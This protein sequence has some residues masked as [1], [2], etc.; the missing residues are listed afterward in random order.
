M[1]NAK[2]SLKLTIAALA[3]AWFMSGC[4][5]QLGQMI[6]S[7]TRAVVDVP[8][9]Q[10]RSAPVKGFVKLTQV[11]DARHFEAAPRNPSV[12]SLQNA[13]QIKDSS[14]TSR[15]IG[16]R[17]DGLQNTGDILLP[18][19]RPVEQLVREAVTQALSDMGYSVVDAKSP[20]FANAPSLQIDI[21]QFWTWRTNF[22]FSPPVLEFESILRVKSE[23]LIGGKEER[24]RAFAKGEAYT[25]AEWKRVMQSGMADL[26]EKVRASV[27]RPY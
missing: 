26:I 8:M 13:E 24:I 10:A 25:G 1:A 16:R 19:R 20:E 17:S 21:Q 5:A 4:G 22:W 11:R 2:W 6:E 15:A 18:E 23:A 9:P 7:T 27:R 14:I 3:L 12:P